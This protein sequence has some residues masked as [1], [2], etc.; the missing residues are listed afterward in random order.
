ML[1]CEIAITSLKRDLVFFLNYYRRYIK[2]LFSSPTTHNQQ[3]NKLN[4][5]YSESRKETGIFLQHR[6]QLSINHKF[7]NCY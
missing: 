1:V 4:K 6:W 3:R 2:L 5:L 7:V